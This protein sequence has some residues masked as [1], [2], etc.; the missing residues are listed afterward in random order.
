MT[1]TMERQAS[2]RPV[3]P[4]VGKARYS[5]AGRGPGRLAYLSLL[6]LAMFSAFPLYWSLVVASHD[7]S[8]L[9]QVPPPF[10]IGGNLI[11]NVSRAF[12]TVPFAKALTN[13][14][15]VSGA[16][17]VSVVTFSTLAGFAFAKLRFRG[18]NLLLLAI[19]ATMMVPSQLGI[20]PLYMLMAKYHLTGT[21][22]A[23]IIPGLVSAFGVFFMTQYLGEAIPNELLEAAR[24]DGCTTARIFWHV[25]VPAARPAAGVLG[26]LTFMTAW[27]DFFWPLVVLTPE[28]PT[29]QVA[30]SQLSSG[31]IQDFSL[32]LTGTLIAT[33]PLLVVF[34]ILGKQ[35]IGGIMQGAVKG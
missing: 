35:I 14:F 11:E 21:M 24:A 20:I 34:V 28:E 4:P 25:V 19:I 8:V 22:G 16:I 1:T 9:G 31:Y 30:L 15:L 32:S 12:G 29:V 7:N 10:G 6:A 26:M 2:T 18:R 33:V 3:D 17:T 5:A 13:S 27:N 23:V